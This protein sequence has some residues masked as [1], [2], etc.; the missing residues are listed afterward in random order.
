ML[1]GS[2]VNHGQAA[3]TQGDRAVKV[4]SGRIWPTVSPFVFSEPMEIAIA[5]PAAARVRNRM[6]RRLIHALEPRLAEMP[7]AQGYPAEPLRPWNAHRFWP[8]AVEVEVHLECGIVGRDHTPG[9]TP[10]ARFSTLNLDLNRALPAEVKASLI[11]GY[12]AGLDAA[13][14]LTVTTT[15]ENVFMVLASSRCTRCCVSS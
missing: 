2:K 4:I 14:K 3:V 11:S 10:A 6:A 5:A 9:Q 7:L 1:A 12:D 13:S 15:V 8:A